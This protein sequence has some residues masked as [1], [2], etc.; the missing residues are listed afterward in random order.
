[1]STWE[2]GNTWVSNEMANPDKIDKIML[3]LATIEVHL[4]VTDRLTAFS[5]KE[6]SKTNAESSN[7][8]LL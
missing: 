6:L 8:V 4:C 2:M 3:K 5:T 1:M 7:G